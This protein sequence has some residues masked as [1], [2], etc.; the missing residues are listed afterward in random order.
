ML[1]AK[2][3][4]MLLLYESVETDNATLENELASESGGDVTMVESLPEL[5]VMADKC[6]AD[7]VV[8]HVDDVGMSLL[9]TL[10]IFI[11]QYHV[12]VV[13][14]AHSLDKKRIVE[15]SRTG[16]AMCITRDMVAGH[17]AVILETARVRND[18]N[19]RH[20]LEMNQL[21]AQLTERKVIEKAKGIVMRQRRST[22]EEAYRSLRQAAMNSNQRLYEVAK[23][24]VTASEL[25]G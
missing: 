19:V 4:P 9:E 22:E 20:R 18:E 21:Q 1:N 13:V 7:L 8:C 10:R 11:Q 25:L 3:C 12:P 5:K 24:I 23:G 15:A 16:V 2:R 14:I 17:V 6:G